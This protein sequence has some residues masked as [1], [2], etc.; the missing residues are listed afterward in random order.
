MNYF[1]TF[2]AQVSVMR[3]DLRLI[4][5]IPPLLLA[6]CGPETPIVAGAAGVVAAASIPVFHRTPVDMVVS[7][8]TGRDCSVVNLDKGEQYC[9]PK[10]RPPS[11]PEFCTRSLGVPDCWKDPSKV[12]NNPRE[13]ADGPRALTPEQERTTSWPGLW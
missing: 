2:Q 4:I 13:L 10:E 1:F 9:H 7:A 3:A 8:V 11:E 12:P 6:G 5:L